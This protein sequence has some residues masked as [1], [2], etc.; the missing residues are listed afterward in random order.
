MSDA[1]SGSFVALRVREFR[2]LWFG[3]IFSFL[4]FFMAMIVQSVVAFEISGK[5]SSVGLIVAAQ[6]IAMI[7]LGP[8]GGAFADRWPKRSVVIIGQLFA[9]GVFLWT[10]G[11]I[12]TGAI[13][14]LW[15]AVSSLLVGL[16]VA[17]LG[18]SRQGM[19]IEV[20]PSSIRGNAMTVNNLANTFSRV[21]GPVV[22]GALLTWEYSGSVGAYV[23]M[24][25]FYVVSAISVGL[26]PRLP[27]RVDA[28]KRSV[29]ADVG[30]GLGYVYR[31]KRLRLLVIL[32]TFVIFLGFPHITVLPGLTENVFE[33]TAT[34]VS[35]LF[36]V[37]AIGA[38]AASF[39]V[40]RF[41]DSPK[42]D[43]IY[44]GM[45]FLFGISLVG[46]AWA[47]TF[48]WAEVALF[49][50][51]AGS[52]GFQS[53]NAAVIAR[54]TEPAFIGRVMS[55]VMLA[56]G[57]FGLM[58][59]PYGFLADAIGERISLLL[60]GVGVLVVTLI[61]GFLLRQERLSREAL[62]PQS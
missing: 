22:A 44:L 17:F 13:S 12:L 9:A 52:G 48:L 23:A 31:K 29:L 32:F 61:F 19:V 54:D 62:N 42:A 55:L 6:G 14:I 7:L 51:G 5:N 53:L 49:G 2:I 50:V 8:I 3:T 40:T 56:F 34:E 59:L 4:A 47:P 30:D 25:V 39:W 45:A 28:R 10:A 43:G 33:R 27:V 24:M 26:L 46:L 41:G 18:P 36:F 21:F 38:L 20:V 37:S 57:G 15:L 16:S 35:E 58:A 1:T 60:M 11:M